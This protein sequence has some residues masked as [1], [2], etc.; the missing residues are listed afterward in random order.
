MQAKTRHKA[1]LLTTFGTI[2]IFFAACALYA[3]M[4][5]SF[6]IPTIERA[7]FRDV[8]IDY[9]GATDSSGATSSAQRHWFWEEEVHYPEITRSGYTLARWD[10]SDDKTRVSA[11]WELTNYALTYDLVY[12]ELADGALDTLPANCTIQSA[13]FALPTPTR[14]A[15][16]FDGWT[17]GDSPQRITSVDPALIRSDS[18]IQAHWEPLGIFQPCTVYLGPTYEAVPYEYSIDSETAPSDCCGVWK[19]VADVDDG[20]STYYIGHNPGVFAQVETFNEGS[21]F[22]ICDDEGHLGVYEVVRKIVILYE[23]T[24]WTQSLANMTMP[25]AEYASLQTCRGDKVFMDIYVAKRID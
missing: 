18:T 25:D 14:Y 8:T 15:Y 7:L 20:K 16:V 9:C 13:A 23:G 6:P 19:G 17:I 3:A 22:A 21:R 5:M 4:T 1:I 11:H 12:G 24:M 10:I 2:V